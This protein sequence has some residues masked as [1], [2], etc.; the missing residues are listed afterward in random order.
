MMYL[1]ACGAL[2]AAGLVLNAGDRR[3][4]LLTALVGASVFLPAPHHSAEAFY[5]FCIAVDVAIGVLAWATRSKAGAAVADLCV[6]LVI[7]H[8]MGYA[9]DGSSPFSPYR[10]IVKIL[11]LSQLAACVALSPILAPILRN[12]DAT[13]T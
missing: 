5:T 12:H 7:A 13:T 11:E 10:I 4:L 3:A 2:L 9:L 1:A 8:I 6:L